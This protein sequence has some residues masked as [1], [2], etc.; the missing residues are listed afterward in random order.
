MSTEPE[1]HKRKITQVF[2][3]V[4]SGYDNPSQR[5]FQLCADQLVADIK[6]RQG[7]KLLD[8]ATG[9]GAVAVAAARCIG[10]AGRIQ[11]IDLSE[12]MLDRASINLQKTGLNNADFHR[13]DAELLEFESD[14]FD[15]ATCSF[16]IFFIPDM[17]MALK[18][19]LRVLKP[20]GQ[21]AFTTFSQQA[22][23]P[24][25]DM[26][27]ETIETFGVEFSNAGWQRLATED[28][29]CDLLQLAGFEN[30]QVAVK[31][32]G[33]YLNNE[34]EWWELIFNSGFRGYLEQL[35]PVQQADFRLQHLKQ[36]QD[37]LDDKGLWL[38]VETLFVRASKPE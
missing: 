28:K 21:L 27:K 9:T 13:M 35:G 17:L 30:M 23:F 19:W 7:S 18:E 5:F 2:D 33:Y 14:Y 16:G 8:I 36:V 24:Q 32:M 31:Q 38:N 22:F 11:A 26:F 1:Q 37:L 20:G 34:Q 10:P 6:P 25:A 29:C 15:Y 4:A 3:T 12:N